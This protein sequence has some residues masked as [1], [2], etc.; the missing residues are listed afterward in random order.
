[1]NGSIR[2]VLL[3]VVRASYPHKGV[4]TLTTGEQG[5]AGAR[6]TPKPPGR[7]MIEIWPTM[8]QKLPA[9]NRDLEDFL[10]LY[11]LEDL[12]DEELARGYEYLNPPSV[13][14]CTVD[15]CENDLSARGMCSS[16]YSQWYYSTKKAKRRDE[17]NKRKQV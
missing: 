4:G 14:L 15:G 7:A 16:H 10:E 6:P 1:M 8:W 3:P 12:T 17:L 9:R 2:R 11:L 13:E 5:P